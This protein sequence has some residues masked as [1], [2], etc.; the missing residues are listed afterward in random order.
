M[1]VTRQY[2]HYGRCLLRYKGL[3]PELGLC[4]KNL[5]TVSESKK[6]TGGS[7]AF[8]KIFS[9]EYRTK[10]LTLALFLKLT[11]KH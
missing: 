8:F 6:K 1:K 3:S 11:K 7:H 10:M 2:V 9:L 4:K 5:S